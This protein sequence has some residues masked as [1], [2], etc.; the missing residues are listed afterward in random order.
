MVVGAVDQSQIAGVYQLRFYGVQVGAAV[1]SVLHHLVDARVR[2]RGGPLEGEDVGDE[3]HL[4]RREPQR[5][6]MGEDRARYR[7]HSTPGNDAAEPCHEAGV[8]FVWSHL[9]WRVY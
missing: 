2:E 5:L 3:P 6:L 7:R 4:L 1:A 8:C 9:C